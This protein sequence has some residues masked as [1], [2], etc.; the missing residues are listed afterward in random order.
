MKITKVGNK[1]QIT[2][3]CPG[4]SKLIN[5]RFNL[6]E[7]AELRRT[8]IRL[9]RKLGILTPPDY[10]VNP[11]ADHAPLTKHMSVD[12]LMKEY[13]RLYGQAHW[14]AGT[15]SQNQQRI[16]DYI[17]PYIGEV[18]IRSL[19]THRLEQFYEQLLTSPAVKR[20]GR[21]QENK[22]VSHSVLEKI[23][24]LIRSALNQ[25]LRWNYLEGTNPALAVQLPRVKK[26]PRKIWDD[27]EVRQALESCTD[28][29]LHLCI[30]I[31]L[32]CSMRIGEILG[33]TWDCIHIEDDLLSQNEA[34][35]SVEK[36]LR[37][38]N[39]DCVEQL[40]Q[41]GRDEILFTFPPLKKTESTTVLVLKTPK[42]DS[43]VRNIYIPRT[44]AIAM[45]DMKCHQ[46]KLKADLGSEYHD[47][48]LVIAQNNGRP[49]EE[50][51][52]A[53][54]LK[55]MIDSSDLKTVVFHSLRHSSTSLKLRISCGDIKS[56]QGDTGHSQSN[57]VTDVYAHI[58]SEQRKHLAQKM[59]S[60]FFCQK[61]VEK[62]DN[63]ATCLTDPPVSDVTTAKAIKLLQDSPETAAAFLQM[64]QIFSK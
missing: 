1:F 49:Y 45:Q 28:P 64:A 58:L 33:L 36:E 57:M 48:N 11:D 55:K 41:K 53:K 61:Q 8:E 20:K 39:K 51:L 13:V 18:P 35:L 10:L 30:L 37:R 62:S 46:E 9:Q 22:T 6:E 31:A 47:F 59:D 27:R 42:T 38:L 50:R 26:Q 17:L 12:C 4:Y 52:I 21:E 7:E 43:S 14:S 32:G 23:H 19:T 25:A 63:S 2:Y 24:A 29:V 54:R 56:V 3:R 34:Y 40:R 44:V 15:L 16:R 5:E 60:E